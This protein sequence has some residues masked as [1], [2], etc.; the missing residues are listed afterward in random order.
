MRFFLRMK[1]FLYWLLAGISVALLWALP[2]PAQVPPANLVPS[3]S[4]EATP[5]P[6][7]ASEEMTAANRLLP[8]QWT[9]APESIAAAPIYLDG[10]TLF[11]V[12]APAVVDQWPAEERAQEIQ[13]R[14]YT[15]A[16][17][18]SPLKITVQT[19]EP[20]N[21]PVIFV[22]DQPLLT[23]TSLDARLSGHA[24]PEDR[25]VAIS[26]T[27]STAFSRYRQERSPQFWQRQAKVAVGIVVVASLLQIAARRIGRKLQQRQV[28]LAN[29][30]T[31][32]GQASS[33]SSRP[34]AS[35]PLVEAPP[36]K[37]FNSVLD[38][39]KARLDNRQKRKINEIERGL[40]VLFQ[41]GLWISSCLWILALFP[42]SRWL[43]TLLLQW[44]KI[45]AKILLI[46]GLASLALRLSSLLID[47]VSLALQE[48]TRWAPDKSRRLNL[49][50]STFSQVAKGLSGAII[51]GVT[52]LV[53]LAI[54]G[55]Q[56]GPVLAG[57]GIIG[58]G[59]SLASQGLIKDFINGFLILVEDHFGIGDVITVE[60]LTGAVE[61]V[62]LRITQLR[63]IEGRLITIPNSQINIVQN[64][65]KDWAQINLS[66]D[67]ATT[68]NLD[69][70]LALL[71]ATATELA[72]D[73]QWKPLILEPPEMLGVD[74]IDHAGVTLR[75]LLKTQPLQQWPVAFELRQR[76]KQAFDQAGIAI[77]VPQE[78]LELRWQGRSD[79]K[80]DKNGRDSKT[81]TVQMSAEAPAQTDASS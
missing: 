45:P 68:T 55:V 14:L 75:L 30:K 71:K 43:S 64:L 52:V 15:L 4:L 24:S 1:P 59:I 47:K 6:A 26:D 80:A 69:K 32:L 79:R 41:L 35:R 38:Q 53:A 76:I 63:D 9:I 57:A 46:I 42:Y 74:K 25:A 58:V 60:G 2:A 51:F 81:A 16:R 13:Q 50:F 72:E 28:R 61:H 11:W 8:D 7:T 12:S 66:I 78:H 73:E 40:L 23:V 44:M 27:L 62:N 3:S 31:Q 29:A 22:D 56:V 5:T 18:D 65:S 77:G 37:T 21:L 70:A 19:D 17:S 49:R 20:S 67:V 10:R 54:A 34:M 48:G 33:D 36:A 39:L